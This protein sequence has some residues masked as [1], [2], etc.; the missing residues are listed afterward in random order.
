MRNGTKTLLIGS[1][2][3]GKTYSLTTLIEAGLELAVIITDPGGEETL[4]AAMQKKRLS[5]DK[6]YTHYIASASQSW[7][8]LDNTAKQINTM[9]YQALSELKYGIDKQGHQQF[10]QLLT[11]LSN[12]KD[13]RTGK[14]L[15]PVD[16]WGPDK[17]LAVDSISGINTMALDL[18]VGGKPAP[19]QGEW[20]VAMNIEERLITKLVA[21]TKCFLVMTAH[22]DPELDEVLGRRILMPALLGKKLAPK[23]PR[24]F[25]DV[26]LAVKE[27]ENFYWSTVEP[28]VSLKARNLPLSGKLPPSFVPVVNTWK[29]RQVEEETKNEEVKT[30]SIPSTVTTIT[31][32]TPTVPEQ[33]KPVLNP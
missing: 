15:G 23:L 18:M 9:G 25:S 6:L 17:A 16:S 22:V 28:N 20:G 1:Y 11:C 8:T 29:S 33:S 21:D 31:T 26:V 30:G 12:F 10:I 5:M 24:I 2:G 32:T 3:T 27:A 13:D 7:A 19:H 14:I 4:Y